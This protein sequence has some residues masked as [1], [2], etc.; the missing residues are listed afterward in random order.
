MLWL[1][2]QLL[3]FFQDFLLFFFYR[4]DE[5]PVYTQCTRHF[6]QE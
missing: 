3:H 2:Q 4:F 1:H 5:E 6:V